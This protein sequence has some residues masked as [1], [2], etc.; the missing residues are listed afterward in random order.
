[1]GTQG[2][3]AEEWAEIASRGED[4]GHNVVIRYF[5]AGPNQERA[6]ILLYHRH[7]DGS[8]CGGSVTFDVPATAGSPRPKWKVLSWEPL[9]L[10][11]SIMDKSCIENLHGFIRDGKWC[12]V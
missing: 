4:I 5:V 8:I 1:M 11:P 10:E 9:T 6:G 2:H 7:R 3:E 12:P